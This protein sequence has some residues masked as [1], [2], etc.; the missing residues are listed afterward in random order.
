MGLFSL[1]ACP[2]MAR[3]RGLVRVLSVLPSH[4]HRL[5]TWEQQHQ[6]N[7][8]PP[9]GAQKKQQRLALPWGSLEPAQCKSPTHCRHPVLGR[10][11][12]SQ[13]SPPRRAYV[14]ILSDPTALH[15]L[16]AFLLRVILLTGNLVCFRHCLVNSRPRM[17]S[18]VLGWRVGFVPSR[19]S[20]SADIGGACH[21]NVFFFSR[22]SWRR[23]FLICNLHEVVV[24]AVL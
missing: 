3:R 16:S 17:L 19:L 8:P 12:V 9:R 10:P 21:S 7:Q 6:G 22:Q 20:L 13:W 24:F 23:F 11:H 18:L 4:C 5:L 15:G 2:D 1:W 14:L